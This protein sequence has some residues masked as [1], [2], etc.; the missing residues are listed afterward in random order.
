VEP[1][2]AIG[3][4][5]RTKPIERWHAELRKFDQKFITW[6]GNNTDERPERLAKIEAQHWA[7]LA[8]EAENPGIP[9]IEE[10]IDA[11]LGWCAIT[12]NRKTPGYGKYLLGM[13]PEQC[14][15]AKSPPEGFP[16]ITEDEINLQTCERRH[17]KVAT[18][19]Q[20][21]IQIHGQKLEYV[22]PELFLKQGEMVEVLISRITYRTVTVIYPVVGGTASCIAEVKQQ[23]DWVPEGEDA[24]ERMRAAIRAQ[25]RT[26]RAIK[27]GLNAAAI[28]SE[29]ANPMEVLQAVESLPASN[30]LASRGLFGG[31]APHAGGDAG[32]TTEP[33]LGHPE[34]GSVEYRATRH[35]RTASD[36]ADRWEAE[37]K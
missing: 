1:I 20:I 23:Y 26:K 11:Y 27:A 30:P 33:P 32:A 10:Y 2:E 6:T 14:W 34:I 28:I 31:A 21:N 35:S 19:G 25:H 7:W 8:G 17:E 5:P 18:G 3:N 37:E 9:T 15:N 24:Q 12:W 29:A 16:P 4:N 36:I 13:T 22:A